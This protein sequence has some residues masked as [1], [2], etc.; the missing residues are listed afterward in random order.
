[1]QGRTSASPPTQPYRPARP[2][3][4]YALLA[5][6]TALCPPTNRLLDEA[7]ASTLREKYGEKVR[8]AGSPLLACG[9]PR[10]YLPRPARVA[11]C[12]LCLLRPVPNRWQR[13]HTW[14]AKLSPCL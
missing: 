4:V 14:R 3:Q 10:L 9:G 6:A 12:W 7:V 13:Q 5:I 1:M 2:R 8:P 11:V